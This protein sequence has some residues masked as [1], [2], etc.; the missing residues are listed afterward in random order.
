M[1]NTVAHTISAATGPQLNPHKM[2]VTVGA[3]K[4]KVASLVRAIDKQELLFKQHK[5]LAKQ[6]ALLPVRLATQTYPQV[7]TEISFE[8]KCAGLSQEIIR[9]DA[10]EAREVSWHTPHGESTRAHMHATETHTSNTN[11]STQILTQIGALVLRQCGM[12]KGSVLVYQ[13]RA[14]AMVQAASALLW[15]ANEDSLS[16]PHKH[17]IAGQHLVV[18]FST[19]L[20]RT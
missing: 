19:W 3:G 8:H 14:K 18:P 9:Q 13:E 2:S 17:M 12:Q 5:D 6:L 15:G 7:R 16:A 1:Y 10:K 11:L 20:F 4:K